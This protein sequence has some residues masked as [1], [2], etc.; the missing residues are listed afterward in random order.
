MTITCSDTTACCPQCGR[1]QALFF[2]MVGFGIV[3][4]CHK[5]YCSGTAVAEA[6][7]ATYGRMQTPLVASEVAARTPRAPTR[8]P[9]AL[10]GAA[11]ESSLP[12]HASIHSTGSR[13][14]LRK[15]DWLR[16]K[17]FRRRQSPN[18]STGGDVANAASAQAPQSRTREWIRQQLQRHV[19]AYMAAELD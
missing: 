8:Q 14:R 18:P 6:V 13:R 7:A 9:L 16:R 15:R 5:M 4:R 10:L 12:A 11:I 19:E 17:L 1:R 3:H 2:G